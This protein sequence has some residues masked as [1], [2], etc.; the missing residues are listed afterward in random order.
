MGSVSLWSYFSSGWDFSLINLTNEFIFGSLCLC[1]TFLDF[2]HSIA[3]FCQ[4]CRSLNK[5]CSCLGIKI[6]ADGRTCMYSTYLYVVRQVTTK[7]ILEQKTS[8]GSG[9]TALSCGCEVVNLKKSLVFFCH[10]MFFG[11]FDSQKTSKLKFDLIRPTY[12][13]GSRAFRF[14]D[15]F[16]QSLHSTYMPQICCIKYFWYFWGHL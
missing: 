5:V 4:C 6:V 15:I 3:V 8:G 10:S 14:F 2:F 16:A 13:G 9:E 12:F 11:L 1:G 7:T